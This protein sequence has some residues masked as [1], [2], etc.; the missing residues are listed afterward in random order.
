MVKLSSCL[1]KTEIQ[2]IELLKK[3]VDVK[4]EY[5]SDYVRQLKHRLLTKRKL[6]TNDLLEINLVLEKIQSL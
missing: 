3:N 2:F 1:S 4:S 6:L 5:K